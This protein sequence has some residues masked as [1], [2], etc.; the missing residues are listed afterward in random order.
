MIQYMVSL[1]L[2]FASNNNFEKFGKRQREVFS[3]FGDRI[4]WRYAPPIWLFPPPVLKGPCMRVSATRRV[5]SCGKEGCNLLYGIF[6]GFGHLFI[7][8]T[9]NL[10]LKK[11]WKMKK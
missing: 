10:D 7:N 6:V 11:N 1:M 3:Y 8:T 5:D 2:C 4:K 9:V